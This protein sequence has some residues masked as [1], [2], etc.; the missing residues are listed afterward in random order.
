MLKDMLALNRPIQLVQIRHASFFGTPKQLENFRFS[1][2]QTYTLFVDVD[3]VLVHHETKH[4]LPKVL[5]TMQSWK[6]MGHF[7]I[8]TS[9]S[10]LEYVKELS[11]KFNLPN[12]YIISDL[13]PG[14]RIIINDIKPYLPF[15]QMADGIC[16]QRDEGVEDINI[17]KYI[18]PR[19]LKHFNGASFAKTYLVTDNDNV[20]VRKHIL[21]TEKTKDHVS[22]LRRQYEDLMRWEYISKG[23]VPKVL[24]YYESSSHL[25]FD[26]EYLANYETLSQFDNDTV[27]STLKNL[28]S[29]ISK[30]IYSFKRIIVD[31]GKWMNE[32][33]QSK[34]YPKFENSLLPHLTK[35]NG[36]IIN[37][38]KYTDLA[39]MFASIP[40]DKFAPDY[41]GMIH[42]DL[43]LENI[44][45]NAHTDDVKVIDHAGSRYIDAIEMDIGKLF[46]SLLCSYHK[47][48]ILCTQLDIDDA[49]ELLRYTIPDELVVTKDDVLHKFTWLKYYN[50]NIS[51]AYDRG[52]FFMTTYFI[53]MLPFFIAKSK[54]HA[55]LLLL[56]CHVYLG[57]LCD[58]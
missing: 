48:D 21:K 11:N 36:I 29:R 43:T 5:E 30:D 35:H 6:N 9:A 4:L 57:Q 42:G 25:Y 31:K 37:G 54:S 1:R 39:R 23:I 22:T 28:V 55:T 10:S 33:M 46:Q 41:E 13:S 45:Y 14:P 34:I 2:A 24:N 8:L 27:H 51:V 26:M 3:G 53:R 18:P 38:K 58:C 20:F 50:S 15:Y 47:W 16:T 7:I 56:L 40:Y 12:D 17:S 44:M 49:N 32:F 19:I 52:V